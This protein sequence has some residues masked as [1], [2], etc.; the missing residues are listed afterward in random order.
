MINPVPPVDTHPIVSRAEWLEARKA[1][2]LQEK[3]ETHLR[4]RINT[5]RMA[6]PWVKVESAYVFETPAGQ[7]TLAELFDG[8]NQLII[9]HFMLGPEWEAGC[10]GCSFLADHLDGTLAHLNN[11]DVTLVAVSRG[12]LTRIAAYKARMGWRFPWVSSGGSDFNFDFG[13]SF[14]KESVADGHA[15]YNFTDIGV[16][17]GEAPKSDELPGL[18][19]FY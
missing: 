16:A 17:A 9:Y 19:A 11:H 6:L 5:A 13:V 12:P 4:D 1:L 14:T 7:Q 10:P 8:R 15:T 3:E 18:S 2:L